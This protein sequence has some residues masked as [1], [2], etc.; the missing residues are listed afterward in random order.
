MPDAELTPSEEAML[1]PLLAPLQSPPATPVYI[2]TNKVIRLVDSEVNR[3]AKLPPAT[4]CPALH[5]GSVFVSK[6][7]IEL[8]D[9]LAPLSATDHE[10]VVNA[11][12]P[13]IRAALGAAPAA[14][15]DAAARAL[16]A[17]IEGRKGGALSRPL[18]VLVNELAALTLH[19][20]ATRPLPTKGERVKLHGLKARPDLNGCFGVVVTAVDA[21]TGRCGVEVEGNSKAMAL[22]ASNLELVREAS[23]LA[24]QGT[25]SERE[26]REFRL[27]GLPIHDFLRLSNGDALF[28]LPSLTRCGAT[29]QPAPPRI[30]KLLREAYFD[31]LEGAG[32]QPDP[33]HYQRNASSYSPIFDGERLPAPGAKVAPGAPSPRSVVEWAA[34]PVELHATILHGLQPL[35]EAFCG[36]PLEPTRFFGVRRYRRGAALESHVDSDPRA[37]MIGISLTVDAEGLEEPWLLCADGAAGEAAGAAL[38]VGQCF[39]YEACRVRHHRPKA[40]RGDVFANAFAHF[41]AVPSEGAGGPMGAD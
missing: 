19:R 33:T 28:A 11:L 36:Q 40:L 1:V 10:N 29:V 15:H 27:P 25:A 32:C 4:S 39:I 14:T 12:A 37:R 3:W 30:L 16:R 18:M 21:N 34:I 24:S 31:V 17:L 22:K 6:A 8:M 23:G 20:E 26:L 2:A 5:H 9:V 41:T 35:A 13:F 7:D 38:P